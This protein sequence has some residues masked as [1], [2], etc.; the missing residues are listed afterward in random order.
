LSFGRAGITNFDVNNLPKCC[1]KVNVETIEVRSSL[2]AKQK[3][4]TENRKL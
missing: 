3:K 4:T 1:Q 2:R